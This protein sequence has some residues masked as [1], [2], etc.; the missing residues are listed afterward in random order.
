MLYPWV[1]SGKV[2]NIEPSSKKVTSY[3]DKIIKS[4]S[5]EK[6]IENFKICQEIIDSIEL[7]TDDQIK[8]GKY[9]SDLREAAI[10]YFGK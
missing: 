9:S 8:R 10:A 3:C 6:Y 7:P 5:S 1:V 4:L 2:D